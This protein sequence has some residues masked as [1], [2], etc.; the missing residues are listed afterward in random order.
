MVYNGMSQLFHQM[1][2]DHHNRSWFPSPGR[3]LSGLTLKSPQCVTHTIIHGSQAVHMQI[4][5]VLGIVSGDGESPLHS[6]CIAFSASTSI[7]PYD[8]LQPL[9]WSL[10]DPAH[11]VAPECESRGHV[12][13]SN[14]SP[15][16]HQV[17]PRLHKLHLTLGTCRH[18]ISWSGNCPTSCFSHSPLL[19]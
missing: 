2:D 18:K 19:T 5:R 3:L 9:P 13:E 17:S 11:P 14:W 1:S 4:Q 6:I 16:L 7:N 8:P 10:A 12:G 15:R